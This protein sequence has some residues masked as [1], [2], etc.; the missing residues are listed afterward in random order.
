VQTDE[1]RFFGKPVGE[2]WS[3]ADL[4]AIE[5][6][7]RVAT[8]MD[9]RT[10]L[11]GLEETGDNSAAPGRADGMR[12]WK[13]LRSSIELCVARVELVITYKDPCCSL[14][15]LSNSLLLILK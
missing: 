4:E 8:P 5:Y 10:A 9:L 7:G 13:G 3:A 11:R 15:S 12:D 14:N 1:A 6:F 2:L